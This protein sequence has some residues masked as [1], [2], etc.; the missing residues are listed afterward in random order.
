[1]AIELGFEDAVFRKEIR[2]DLLLVLL[3]P[4]SPRSRGQDKPHDFYTYCLSSNDSANI[5]SYQ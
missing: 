4:S 5:L 1:M 3:E 2:S